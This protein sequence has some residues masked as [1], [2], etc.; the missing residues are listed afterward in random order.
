MIDAGSDVLKTR[1]K[2]INCP[3]LYSHGDE[4]NINSHIACVK[5]YELTAS[6]DKEMKSWKSL[7]HE[8]KFKFGYCDLH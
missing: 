1:A 6:K 3:I 8:C 2:L 4:D 5:A 7:Y